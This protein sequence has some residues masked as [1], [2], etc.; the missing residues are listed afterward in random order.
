MRFF[1]EIIHIIL[2][3]DKKFIYI[4][5]L[6]Y[7]YKTDNLENQIRTSSQKT[8]INFLLAILVQHSYRF[9]VPKALL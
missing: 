9:V 1:K 6:K 2:N 4:T 5:K 8:Y 7:K 3:F